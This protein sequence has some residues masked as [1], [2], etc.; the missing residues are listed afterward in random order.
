V[1]PGFMGPEVCT[2]LGAFFKKRIQNYEY[3]I[4]YKNKY[5]ER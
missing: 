3:K 5:L 2:I 4:R 1:D